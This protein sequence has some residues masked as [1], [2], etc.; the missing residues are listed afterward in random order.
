MSILNAGEVHAIVK[1]IHASRPRPGE[2]SDVE[3]INAKVARIK[4]GGW[5]MKIEAYCSVV[6]KTSNGKRLLAKPRWEWRNVAWFVRGKEKVWYYNNSAFSKAY[7]L[8]MQ[9]KSEV[10]QDESN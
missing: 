9:A 10:A 8:D 2:M 1:E 3:A 4:E 5:R 6:T 7:A